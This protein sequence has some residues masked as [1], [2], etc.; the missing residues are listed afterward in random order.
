MIPSVRLVL[1][2]AG[3]LLATITEAQTVVSVNSNDV[4]SLAIPLPKEAVAASAMRVRAGDV[5]VS[6]GIQ[7]QTPVDTAV[8]ALRRFAVSS[9][10]KFT[11]KLVLSQSAG[12]LL[13]A[14]TLNR[15]RSLPNADQAY[16]VRPL[17]NNAGLLL[18]ANSAVGLLFATRTLEQLVNAP[19]SVSAD[20][21]LQI[22][23]ATVTDW[24]DLRD[25]SQ[26]WFFEKYPE[27]PEEYS[28]W[29]FNEL[30][31][32]S[33]TQMVNGV[34]KVVLASTASQQ[35]AAHQHGI[36]F[37]PIMG[38]INNWMDLAGE[39][40]CFSNPKTVDF[41]AKG[42]VDLGKLP[43]VTDVSIWLSEVGP[44]CTCS[45][46]KGKNEWLLETAAVVKA[47]QRAKATCPNLGLRI[48]TTRPSAPV[49]DQIV[50]MVPPETGLYY[51]GF[52]YCP[53]R[54]PL[55]TSVMADYAASG[56][57]LGIYLGIAHSLNAGFPWT[58][59]Q[60]PRARANEFVAKKMSNVV[61]RLWPPNVKFN[62]VNMV[63]LAEFSWNAKG[64]T[65]EQFAYA[66]ARRTGIPNPSQYAKWVLPAGEAGWSFADTELMMYAVA[67]HYWGPSIPLT[68][69]GF[70]TYFGG[71]S[72]HDRPVAAWIWNPENYATAL[73]QANE[74][75]SLAR[76]SG[77]AP[78]IGES[79]AT[80]A[81]I[82]AFGAI[83]TA[84][85]LLGTTDAAKRQQLSNAMDVLRRAADTIHTELLAW[86]SR[87][88]VGGGPKL[89]YASTALQ[90]YYQQ[91]KNKAGTLP[92]PQPVP[93]A[94]YGLTAT[95]GSPVQVSLS[96][97]HNSSDES[98]FKIERRVSGGSF[99]PIGTTGKGVTTYTDST[100]TPATAYR[101][102]V[103]AY[104]ANGNS[105]YSNVAFVDTPG[106][107]TTPA[108]PSGLGATALSSSR[109][110]LA[111]TD[112]STNETGFKIDRR[113]SGT[114]DW[115]RIAAPAA[116]TS[117]YADTGLPAETKFYYQ[118]K[119]Y[120]ASGNSPYSALAY[121][122]TASA[123]QPPAAPSALNATPVS[124]TR[125]D[126]S[127]TDN[128]SNEDGFKIDR[129]T[130][131]TQTW[132]RIATPAANART[133]ADTGLSPATHYYYK[134]KA[135]N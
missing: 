61:G 126:L 113:Q 119:A 82:E 117:A 52:T 41:L 51:Y 37:V 12:G 78:M 72:R 130:S 16:L 123:L 108:A 33:V 83:R 50:A 75:L 116:N 54:Q 10:P 106:G 102:Q 15:L 60:Y 112:N 71:K 25:R 55:I 1:T 68:A 18:V 62:Y 70:A 29:K 80:L 36:R 27:A 92:P 28:K 86:Q 32:G 134:I 77:Y 21:Q 6:C 95:A 38:H 13:D 17:A 97:S 14:A 79:K 99:S 48:L 39:G 4:F 107:G 101:Y 59:P 56:H 120:N 103:R 45:L 3:C 8:A 11:V 125:I 87:V 43:D 67:D 26:C 46:C 127:W 20:T 22:P 5:G 57:W 128:S 111:W 115:V 35:D 30:E 118:V 85:G 98:G 84:L 31:C 93:E 114:S 73:A 132:V 105:P 122:T 89:E 64:R 42:F 129:R 19:K 81:G 91:L 90:E 34:K 65:C 7:G 9:A 88:G 47:Y 124:A 104:N 69:S 121:A 94:P 23:L 135:T 96:W 49:N 44:Y 100:V 58:G 74:A 66:Y 24:P 131:G 110:N 63:A 133:Y 2:L 53:N 40:H 76:Q 109:I